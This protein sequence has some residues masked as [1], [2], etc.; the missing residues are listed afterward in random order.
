MKKF[1]AMFL[2]AVL[3]FSMSTAGAV[4]L[5]SLRETQDFLMKFSPNTMDSYGEHMVLISG[6]IR[7]IRWCNASN[8]YEMTLAVDEEKALVPIGS[9]TPQLAVHFRL[10]VDPMPFAV[11]DEVEVVGSL[12]SLYSSVMLPN[13]DAESINGSEDF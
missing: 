10:H 12:N 13:I 11:G 4:V 8:H 3:I 7:E 6:T 5:R 1:A 2:A 9:D